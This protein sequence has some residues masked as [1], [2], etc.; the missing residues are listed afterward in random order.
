LIAAPLGG[1]GGTLETVYHD[2]QNDPGSCANERGGHGP[3]ELPAIAVFV[4][5]ADCG[6][7][8]CRS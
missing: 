4:L 6:L 1:S 8:G 2:E 3:P 5:E 7:S